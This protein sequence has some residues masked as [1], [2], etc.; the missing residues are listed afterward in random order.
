MN[1]PKEIERKWLVDKSKIPYDLTG[2]TPLKLK[3]AYISFSPTIRIRSTNDQS[4]V[5]CVKSKAKEGS[6]VREEY[7]LEITKEQYEKLLTK[8]EGKVV[9]KDRYVI[10]DGGHTIEIDVFDGELSGLCYAEIEFSS[11]DEAKK[12]P[13]PDWA[14]KDVSFD[15]RY[16][17]TA[18][19]QLGI[20]T[21]AIE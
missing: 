11:D 21:D 10:N 3:Q 4:F 20:P 8:T 15:H 5:L 17:N 1:T 6:L 13:T 16:K 2:I 9:S 18:L 19:A 7:E 14:I 12:Y